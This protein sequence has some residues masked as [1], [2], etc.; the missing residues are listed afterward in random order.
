MSTLNRDLCKVSFIV[1]VAA[2]LTACT[3][4]N[5][6]PV[7]LS[8]VDIGG[9][10]TLD[11]EAERDP[12][13]EGEWIMNTPELDLLVATL[14]PVPNMRVVGGYLSM[15]FADGVYTYFG[16][17]TLQVELD[18]SEGQYLQGDGQVRS[19]GEYATEARTERDFPVFDFLILD[20]TTSES[21]VFE[22]RAYKDGEVQTAP[23]IGPTVTI[24][25]PGQ[26]PYV[27]TDSSL[28]I[29]TQGAAGPVSMFFER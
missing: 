6:E 14:V 26:A 3:L 9:A 13:L 8:P 24:M 1:L 22:W 16:E 15:S 25:P 7:I 4:P 28:V 11:P 27:C 5:R 10:P 17:M 21:D 23:G 20:L 12:C 2:M 19:G 29:D 18:M